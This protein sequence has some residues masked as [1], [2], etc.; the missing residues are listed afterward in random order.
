MMVSVGWHPR[1]RDP[2]AMSLDARVGYGIRGMNGL[3]TPFGEF[4]W[5]D[6]DSQRTRLGARYNQVHSESIALTLELS[7][8]RRESHVGDPEH[9]VGVIGL[10]RF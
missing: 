10:L 3:L 7:G 9:R 6:E 2:S 4:G 1:S 5:W 8:E